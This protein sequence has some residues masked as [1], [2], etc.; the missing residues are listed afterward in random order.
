MASSSGSTFAPA[1]ISRTALLLLLACLACVVFLGLASFAAP[2][3]AAAITI[4]QVEAPMLLQTADPHQGAGDEV[5]D[6]DT[7]GKPAESSGPSPI[8]LLIAALGLLVGVLVVTRPRRR[9][10]D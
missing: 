5:A 10:P 6:A 1:F 4:T 8:L 9:G 7:A 3:G 2:R